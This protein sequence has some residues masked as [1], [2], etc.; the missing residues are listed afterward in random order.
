MIKPSRAVWI[1][2]M[3]GHPKTADEEQDVL[4]GC[5]RKT[6]QEGDEWQQ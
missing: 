1:E 4:V 6:I 2:M 3:V 5:K